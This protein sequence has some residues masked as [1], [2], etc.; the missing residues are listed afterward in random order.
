M[1]L[2]QWK[3]QRDGSRNVWLLQLHQCERS[4]QSRNHCRTGVSQRLLDRL[5]QK[6]TDD[7]YIVQ[8][9]D[10]FFTGINNNTDIVGYSAFG[11]GWFAKAIEA[12]EG[13]S[14][15]EPNPNYVPVEYPNS[16]ATY[17]FG[18]NLHDA[19]VGVYP[20]W[21]KFSRLHGS[22]GVAAAPFRANRSSEYRHCKTAP[23]EGFRFPQRDTDHKLL[24]H[25]V[26]G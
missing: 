19:I 17:P 3:V 11:G 1:G 4:F 7:D 13:T 23:N 20:S 6:A 10:T 12:N 26:P 9:G 8:N 14:D 25:E 16:S 15:T 5:A 22:T 2:E 21:D 18:L 24:R